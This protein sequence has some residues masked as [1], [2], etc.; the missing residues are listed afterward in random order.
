MSDVLVV[1]DGTYRG[2]LMGN[3]F[4]RHFPFGGVYPTLDKVYW[5]YPHWRGLATISL[6]QV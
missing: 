2:M 3:F 6:D 5:A 1:K 4:H